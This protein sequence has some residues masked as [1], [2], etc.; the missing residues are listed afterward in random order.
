V[1]VGILAL[2]GDV[3]EHARALDAAGATPMLV[4]T[5]E[6]LSGVDALVVPGGESTTIGKLLDRFDLLEPIRD[7]AEHGMPLYGTCAGMILMAARVVGKDQA[8]HQLGVMDIDVRRNAYG[9]QVE[10]FEADLEV[11]GIGEPLRAVFIRAPE[12][13]RVGAEVEVLAELDTSPVLVRERHLLASAFH[14]EMTRDHRVHEM[15]VEMVGAN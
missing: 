3:R 7:R 5:P 15:F 10:S 6:E 2:Q 11:R 1:K 13:E 14:P 8:A 9:R 4:R 12:V